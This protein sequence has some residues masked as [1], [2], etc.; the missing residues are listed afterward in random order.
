MFT[1]RARTPQSKPSRGIS[2]I[3]FCSRQELEEDGR[4]EDYLFPFTEIQKQRTL[5]AKTGRKDAC[6]KQRDLLPLPAQQCPFCAAQPTFSIS[7]DSALRHCLGSV[8]SRSGWEQFG[9]SC[10]CQLVLCSLSGS[11]RRRDEC[12]PAGAHPMSG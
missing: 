5:L 3:F 11:S 4:H 9:F 6:L 2:V 7:S 12:S 1:F 8:P 10:C